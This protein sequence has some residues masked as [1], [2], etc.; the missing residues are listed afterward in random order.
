MAD[1]PFPRGVPLYRD[2]SAWNGVCGYTAVVRHAVS[3][4]CYRVSAL[5][6]LS[7]P[8]VQTVF[9]GPEPYLEPHPFL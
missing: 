6:A 4:Q 3:G 2:A 9:W 7:Q 5:Y 1:P 8:C